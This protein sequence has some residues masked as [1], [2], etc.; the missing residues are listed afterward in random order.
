MID[1]TDLQIDDVVARIEELVR[2]R[3]P[4]E[5]DV[6]AADPVWRVGR[7]TVQPAVKAIAPLR[8]YGKE[9]IPLDGGVVLALN[10]FSWLDPPAVR[11]GLPARHLLHGEDRAAPPCRG[12]A[13]SSARSARTRCAAA[14]RTARRCACSRELVAEGRAVGLFVEGTRQE[15]GVP[16]EP[17]PGASMIA[18]Q[19]GVPVVPGAITGPS[20]GSPGTSSPSSIAWGE[21]MDFT[22]LPTNGKGYREASVEIGRAI[23]TLWDFLGRHARARPAAARDA[24]ALSGSEPQGGPARAEDSE[25]AEPSG[26]VAE[27][28]KVRLGAS[29]R[30]C[31]RMSEADEGE[32]DIAVE[33]PRELLGTVAI[34]G[35]PNVGKSTLINRLTSTRAAVVHE[36][37]A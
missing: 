8:V 29:R 3:R 7:M 20:S 16:G 5:P 25:T 28:H 17:K 2:E 22:G 31:G 23:W 9:N 37:P 6:R 18:L 13:R 4:G 24:A 34:V 30:R 26:H 15:S 21:P 12:W 1:T 10:H 36:T 33:P 27:S 32:G 11:C 19:E 35:F 14:N